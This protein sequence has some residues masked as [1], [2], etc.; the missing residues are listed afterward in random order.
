MSIITTIKQY[1]NMLSCLLISINKMNQ[2]HQLTK[3]IEENKLDEFE[4]ILIRLAADKRDQKT[5]DMIFDLIF[6]IAK[7]KQFK[8]LVDIFHRVLF[9]PFNQEKNLTLIYILN[10]VNFRTEVKVKVIELL[11]PADLLYHI[12]RIDMEEDT[13]PLL[14]FYNG[15]KKIPIDLIK[16]Y[17]KKSEESGQF[18]SLDYLGQ[19]LNMVN[20][21]YAK[22]NT[23]EK[24]DK[25]SEIMEILDI[26][27]VTDEKV[28]QIA[29]YYTPEME[30]D[31][32]VLKKLI[33]DVEIDVTRNKAF[34]LPVPDDVDLNPARLESLSTDE[35]YYALFGPCHPY[36][37][38]SLALL[39]IT[40]TANDLVK[41]LKDNE[42]NNIWRKL[43]LNKHFG[44]AR[45]LLDNKNI[46]D[47]QT[48]WFI[49]ACQQC[50]KKIR[51]RSEA[52]RQPRP[53]GGWRGCYCCWSCVRDEL[54]Q[55][56]DYS[57][58]MHSMAATKYLVDYF[59]DQNRYMKVVR[60][61]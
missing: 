22:L 54:S 52:V 35:V 58:S 20:V 27:E 39:S 1:C 32:D 30:S 51:T 46:P 48:D 36:K 10:S 14:I 4:S 56:G 9:E 17:M 38:S 60:R 42:Y 25:L 41:Y 45:M 53:A 8:F 28:R 12:S 31:V 47:D 43:D 37:N 3:L 18:G 49:G 5:V 7:D 15:Y 13:L 40:I 61:K 24:V 59:E 21:E 2:I 29:Y 11:S 34:Y 23:V 19:L 44:G 6:N 26:K 55:F 50:H 33:A 16:H 57:G